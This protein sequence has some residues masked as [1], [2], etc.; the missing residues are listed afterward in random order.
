[1]AAGHLSMDTYLVEPVLHRL[2]ATG[3]ELADAWQAGQGDIAVGEG[4]IGGDELGQAFR[5]TYLGDSE[6]VR[7]N[8]GALPGVVSTDAQ[9]GTTCVAAYC[10]ADSRAAEPF[11]TVGG[12]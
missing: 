1:M 11:R 5:G 12:R 2:S 10:A 4:A 7:A 3:D 9:L 8:A 6:L